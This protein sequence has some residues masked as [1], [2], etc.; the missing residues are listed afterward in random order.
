MSYNITTVLPKVKAMYE[1]YIY[2]CVCV[3]VFMCVCLCM[4]M[5]AC[6]LIDIYGHLFVCDCVIHENMSGHDK[7]IHIFLLTHVQLTT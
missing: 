3:C 1:V 7:Y 6:A 2:I 5:C 4:F